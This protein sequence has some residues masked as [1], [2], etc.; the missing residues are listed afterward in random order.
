[1]KIDG[2]YGLI[3]G[4]GGS[5]GATNTL[6]FTAGPVNGTQGLLGTLTPQTISSGPVVVN[7]SATIAEAALKVSVVN[8]TAVEG[9]PF[10]GVVANFTDDNPFSVPGDFTATINWGD[11]T[12]STGMVEAGNSLGAYYVLVGTDSSHPAHI[13]TDETGSPVHLGPFNTSVTITET[14]GGTGVTA[15][16]FANVADAPL[17]PNASALATAI[18]GIPTFGAVE[19]SPLLNPIN[20]V[21]PLPV[22]AFLDTNP[23]ATP[24]DFIANGTTGVA[25]V[26]WGDGSATLG[27]VI[28]TG[29]TTLPNGQPAASFE[30][31]VYPPSDPLYTLYPTHTYLKVGLAEIRVPIADIGGKASSTVDNVTIADAPLSGIGVDQFA[32]EGQPLIGTTVATFTDANPFVYTTALADGGINDFKATIDWGDGTSGGGS[33]YLSGTTAGAFDVVG[34]HKYNETGLYNIIVTID[35][36]AGDNG[37]YRL[38]IDP[39]ATI[40]DELLNDGNP[41]GVPFPPAPIRV[42]TQATFSIG[43][44]NEPNPPGPGATQPDNSSDFSV[45]INWG[46]GTPADTVTGGVS[47]VQGTGA[48]TIFRVSGTHTYAAAGMRT[49]VAT[50]TD[51][52]DP[53]TIT[54]EIDV[55]DSISAQNATANLPES[56]TLNQI[57]ATFSD[58]DPM[59]SASDFSVD[60]AA[61]FPITASNPTVT[62]IGGG[63]GNP[64]VF[65]V[66]ADLEGDD[67]SLVNEEQ[68]GGQVLVTITNDNTGATAAVTSQVNIYDP[69]LIDPPINVRAFATVPFHADVAS[70][71]TTDRNAGVGAFTAVVNW[72]DGQTSQATIVANGPGQFLVAGNHTYARGGTYSVTTTVRDNAGHSVSDTGAASVSASPVV[73]PRVKIAALRRRRFSG[74]LATFSSPVLTP[75]AGFEALVNWGDG[76][77]SAAV[78]EATG[79]SHGSMKYTIFGTHTYAR[80]KLYSSAVTIIENGVAQAVIQIGKGHG[81]GHDGPALAKAGAARGARTGGRGAVPNR[82]APSRPANP[83]QPRGSGDRQPSLSRVVVVESLTPR[84]RGHNLASSHDAKPVHSKA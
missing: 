2:L 54:R 78:V 15:D 71:S 82:P 20:P 68:D 4:N 12:S 44:F 62:A 60:L 9:N 19:G 48:D 37:G 13:Y 7:S 3:F 73:V 33:V 8:F 43:T 74:A 34:S 64:V 6:F 53:I 1:M 28:S 42:G 30:V 21:D 75:A 32:I 29:L 72:G 56:V 52:D 38:I 77:T 16:G 10:I 40:S 22:S 63:S 27:Q 31:V 81:N 79:K 36:G 69:V 84:R 14:D 11:G 17:V 70:F 59:A 41:A 76:S 24:A 25:L 46:D 5:A 18:G 39:L 58:S 67:S 55:T 83:L 51:A 23:G 65:Q 57:I 49:V 47:I 50:I 45:S 80:R 66:T 35:D 61:G 26:D